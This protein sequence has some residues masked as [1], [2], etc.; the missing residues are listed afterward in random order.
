MRGLDIVL[1]KAKELIGD[2]NAIK[3]ELKE[4][5]KADCHV[6]CGRYKVSVKVELLEV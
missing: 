4:N 5:Q 3:E 6:I 1:N 2:K